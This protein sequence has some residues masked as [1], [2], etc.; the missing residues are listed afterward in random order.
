MS[1]TAL[2]RS[3]RL[4]RPHPYPVE[5]TSA[6]DSTMQAC[7][8]VPPVRAA[9]YFYAATIPF[10]TID[11]GIP[12]LELT[13]VSFF[14]LVGSLIF[15]PDLALR[16]PPAAFG[17]FVLY[18]IVFTIPTALGYTPVQEEAEWQL[19]VLIHLVIMGWVVF[20]IMKN[21]EV[22]RTGLIV[23]GVACATLAA[24]QVTGISETN[25]GYESTSDRTTSFGFHPNNL[26]RILALGMLAIVGLAY[27][28]RR[29]LK[30][31]G[32]LVPAFILLIGYAIIQTGS[33]G[34]LLALFAGLMV[35]VLG[36]GSARSRARNA[37]LVGA[38]V[39][40]IAGLALTSELTASRF[41]DA[42]DDG[43]LARRELI[44]PMAWEM[45][46]EKPLVGWGGKASEYELGARLGHPEEESKNPHN[47]ILYLLVA[48]G[49]VGAVPMLA[50][51]GLALY[52]AWS[53]RTG[54]LG[55]LPLAMLVTVLVANMSGLWLHNKMHWFV[56]ALA[57]ST[58]SVVKVR[59]FKGQIG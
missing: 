26:A 33:R 45:F 57:L 50:G 39:L 53:T 22:A 27:G 34:G 9:F 54:G 40:F 56:I 37:V 10:E 42:L 4:E 11:L 23:L 46:L 19:K 35:I 32:L 5:S 48:T 1:E 51:I 17:L 14:V 7:R 6:D 52:A 47:L 24:L 21:Q 12:V 38:A 2:D 13:M 15:Q 36:D 30:K 44:Y 43:D 16:K 59:Q 25:A 8:V 29:G 31:L 41:E 49:L 20:N 58:V 55:V 28:T 18:V 3:D